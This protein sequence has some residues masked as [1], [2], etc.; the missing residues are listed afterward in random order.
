MDIHGG[1][2]ICMGPNNY[3]AQTYMEAPISVTVEGANIFTR[4]MIIFGQGAIRCHPFVLKEMTAAKNKD[5]KAGLI[6][7]DHALF[8]H[9]GFMASNKVRAFVLGITKGYGA[10][11][12]KGPLKRYYQQFS[13]FSAAFAFVAD[14]ALVS[15]GGALKRKEKLSARLGDTLSLLYMG[16]AVMKYYELEADEEGLPVVQWI[17]DDL[18]YR[19]QTQLDGFLLNMPNRFFAWSMRR[20]VFP[21]GL[22]LHPPADRLTRAV[23]TLLLYPSRV[24]ARL[25]QHVYTKPTEHNPIGSIESVL[26]QVIAAEPLEKKLR[27]AKRDHVIQGDTFAEKVAAAV[28]QSI[29][30][31]T[32]AEQLL[33]AFEARMQIIHVD[34]FDISE[35]KG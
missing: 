35:L 3:V 32:E 29:V 15:M 18:L 13:R 2:G 7:F 24:R 17:C 33:S 5:Q 10:R 23:A 14:G 8:S 31:A 30:S 27:Q 26:E 21:L 19:L 9:L 20:A 22:R 16:S 6:A 25:A 4:S 12:P 11:A 28:E 1:K 34:D